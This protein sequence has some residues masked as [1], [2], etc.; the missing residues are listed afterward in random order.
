MSE[1]HSRDPEDALLTRDLFEFLLKNTPDQVYF[2]DLLN[3]S[4]PL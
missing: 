1:M 3:R 2:K 4:L